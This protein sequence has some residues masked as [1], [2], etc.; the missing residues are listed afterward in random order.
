[1]DKTQQNLCSFLSILL[2]LLT[3]QS[4]TQKVISAFFSNLCNKTSSQCNH[5]PDEIRANHILD[6]E[7]TKSILL[8]SQET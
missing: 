3:K 2:L 7:K 4:F 5:I 6:E 8:T 1:M